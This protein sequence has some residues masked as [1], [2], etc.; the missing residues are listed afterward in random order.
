[1][2]LFKPIKRLYH[3][4]NLIGLRLAPIVLQIEERAAN[5]RRVEYVMATLYPRRTEELST[6]INQSSESDICLFTI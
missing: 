5:P 1:M 3:L 4:A 2:K 6:D